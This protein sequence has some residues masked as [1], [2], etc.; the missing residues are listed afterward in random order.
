M[1]TTKLANLSVISVIT[2]FGLLVAQDARGVNLV[3]NGSF[4]AVQPG[5]KCVVATNGMWIVDRSSVDFT[6]DDGFHWQ[7]AQGTNSVDLSGSFGC[8]PTLDGSIHQDL[9]TQV[10]ASY[11]LRFALAGNFASGPQVKEM[12]LLW[13]GTNVAI[14]FFDTAGRNGTNMGW[15]YY[16]F[17]LAAN[18]STT[19]LTFQTP[20]L[21]GYG[22]VID[23]VSVEQV[24]PNLSIRSSQ[25][26]L[27]WG[28]AT[29]TWYQLQYESSLTTNQWVPFM[30][31]WITGTGSQ[32]CTNDAILVGQV[33]RYYR[34]AVTNSP[35]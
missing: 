11:K 17:I 23:D 21:T 13:G 15:T 10:G 35:P 27:C 7:A 3:Q 33:Q 12:W 6:A 28:T 20:I 31:N 29:N 14:L 32:Y 30:T 9:P 34:V 1:K 25:V 24:I 22:P 4:E 16:E 2:T 5:T 26:E 18:N 8:S 19:R